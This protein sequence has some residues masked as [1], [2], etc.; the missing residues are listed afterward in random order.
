MAIQLV[1]QDKDNE[2]SL[3][4]FIKKCRKFS[5]TLYV[6]EL[7]LKMNFSEIFTF[8]VIFIIKSTF[9]GTPESYLTFCRRYLDVFDANSKYIKS[10]CF[11][12][13]AVNWD[14]AKM[15]CEANNMFLTSIFNFAVQDT[16]LKTSAQVYGTNSPKTIWINGK[17][18]FT[19]NWTVYTGTNSQRYQWAGRLAWVNSTAQNLGNCMTITNTNGQFKVSSSDCQSEFTFV[20]SF[21]KTVV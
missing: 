12:D 7:R 8:F 5:Y 15:I 16:V 2:Y 3:S 6:V 11:V 13:I 18:A 10:V 17:K 20:C 1:T 14:T 21:N 19:G 9:C 4:R